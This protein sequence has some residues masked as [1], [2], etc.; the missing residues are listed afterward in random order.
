MPRRVVMLC[1][2]VAALLPV[3]CCATTT[4]SRR[5]SE[6]RPNFIVLLVDDLGFGDTGFNGHPTVHTPNID[7]LAFGGRV[8]TTWYSG[9]PVCSGSR[10]SLM[11]GRQFTRTGVPGVFGPTVNVGLPL[12][13]TTVAEQL[14]KAGYAT[15]AVGKWH[16][17]Q[18]EPYL[19][20]RRG[21][22]YYLGVPYSVDMGLARA[23]RCN[24]TS[25][26]CQLHGGEQVGQSTW[27]RDV[28]A[29]AGYL[30]P[31]ETPANLVDP[32]GDFLPLVY[33]EAGKTRILEQPLD[34]ARLPQKY[35]RFAVDFVSK[36]KDKPFFL[37]MPFSHVHTT[38]ANQPE[39]QYAGCPFKNT[40]RRGA[41][42][43]ALAEVDWI[44]GN[45][46]RALQDAGIEENTLILFT[47]DN[48]PWMQAGLSA[49]S[50]G[51][52][53]GRFSG[54][55]NTGKGSTWE[56]G[57]REAAFA[58]WKDKIQPFSRSAEVVSSMDVFPTL[59]A[60]AGVPLPAGRVYDGRNM[61]DVILHAE[62]RS[63]HDFLFFYGGCAQ[64]GPSAVRH[65]KWK[66]H[67]CTGPGLGG[68]Q[69][70]KIKKYMEAPLLFNVEKDPSEAIPLNPDGE[71]PHDAEAAAAIGRIQKAHATERATFVYGSLVPEPDGPGEG[72]GRYG[73]CCD[74]SK[75]CDCD[76]APSSAVG[77][78][79]IGSKEHHD[80]YHDTSGREPPLPP[81]LA[82]EML[83]AV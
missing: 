9:C 44:V 38:A 45:V 81:T 32:G 28:Y 47:G 60:L 46:W 41:F 33:Q 11:T 1:S 74:R 8:L 51:L 15:A 77:I 35:N 23:S 16:L 40:T 68:C 4:E 55:W 17:G 71:M 52:L 49:G 75:Q 39:K 30:P 65:G 64:K 73:V 48:G 18:R 57:I 61:A 43:D 83:L 53:T 3:L 19:P 62:G 14:K 25:S 37:Y 29:D 59:S 21:F 69:G 80:A 31:E 36:H 56:G 10:A 78:L 5:A 76:G 67:F 66:A 79:G 6:E 54:Y 70:C 22:D 26:A 63:Q 24:G 27:M 42:G 7:R 58:Y 34:F 50:T 20:G 12:N 72:P 82:Q 13:E 2:A